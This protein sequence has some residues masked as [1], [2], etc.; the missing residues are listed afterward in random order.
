M[1]SKQKYTPV[2][3]SHL[4]SYAGVGA[5]VRD[6]ND[7]LM[8][9]TDIRY[10]TDRNGTC[11]AQPIPYVTRITNSLGIGKDLRMPPQAK[12]LENGALQGHYLPAVLFPKFAVCK[13]CGLLHNNPWK[14]IDSHPYENLKC[15][16]ERCNGPLEQVTWCAVSRQGYLDDVPWHY[17]CHLGGNQS[18]RIDFKDNYLRLIVDKN[19]KKLIQCTR[20]GSS[21]QFAKRKIGV[22]HKQQPW[23]FDKLQPV[24]EQDVEIIEIN[25]PGVYFPERANALVIPPESRIDK[26]T[27]VDRLYNNSHICRQIESIR[28]PLR[29]KGKIKKLATEYRCTAAE[30]HDA[31]QQLKN[32]YPALDKIPL[33]DMLEDE[34]Q[35]FKTPLEN[36]QEDEDFVTDHKTSLWQGVN[37]SISGELL[38]INR[39]INTLIIARRIREI[40][41]FKGFRRQTPDSLKSE[42]VPPD[43]EGK[44]GWLPA[45]E[46]FG[47]GVFFTLDENL[48]AGWEVI[49]GV[50]A[51]ADEIARRYE[52]SGITL[53]DEPHVIP[54]FLLLHTLAH[55][56]IR[57][58]EATSGYPAASLKERIYCSVARKMSGILIYTA[59][60]DIAGSLGGIIESA[61]PVKFLS[62]LDGVFKHARWCSLDPV[63]S[64]HE[65]QGPGW[66]NRAACHACALIPEPSCAFSNVFLDRVFIKGN[67]ELGIPN[68][69]EYIGEQING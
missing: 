1:Q 41:I 8:V 37:P 24:E 55:L 48:L 64:E 50:R 17:I 25:N 47:E 10:W 59:V 2:R 19:G 53:Y 49:P 9:V 60:P 61:E 30:I 45:I 36:I 31:L 16:D 39:F 28:F 57:E 54:R 42:L 40:Q 7:M 5:I 21:S 11:T 52:L 65:G 22:I 26:G 58:L 18:C 44:A 38:S 32:G 46:L 63:C 3:F 14:E 43:I 34:Y 6:T 62:L 23:I 68:L 35:A 67:R 12:E 27:V 51:R 13:K 4:T 33:G 29:K 15:K 20:C 56:L 69:L 66:L